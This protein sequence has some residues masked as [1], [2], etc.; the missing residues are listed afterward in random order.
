MEMDIFQKPPTSRSRVAAFLSATL[1]LTLVGCGSP[2]AKISGSVKWK[3]KPIHDAFVAFSSTAEEENQFF[4]NSLTDGSYIIAA[5]GKR[6]IPPGKYKVKVTFWLYRK[7]KE[8]HP[9]PDGEEG[10]RLK[11]S[12][13][14][15]KL[16]KEFEKD[17]QE[18]DNVIPLDVSEATQVTE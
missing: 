5:G 15:V 10:D 9:L 12:R 6:S 13:N 7:G 2:S 1:M 18:G 8:Y 3:D 11:D 14:A 4:G 17:V 16:E